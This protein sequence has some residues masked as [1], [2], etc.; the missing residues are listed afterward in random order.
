MKGEEVNSPLDSSKKAYIFSF[1]EIE[2]W[3]IEDGWQPQMNFTFNG[4]REDPYKHSSLPKISIFYDLRSSRSFFESLKGEM[5]IKNQK[6]D[7]S[8]TFEGKKYGKYITQVIIKNVLC[9]NELTLSG[10]FTVEGYLAEN[11]K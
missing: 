3:G 11:T 8:I 5:S 6:T 2:L 4:V 7:E 9:N 1:L 10:E